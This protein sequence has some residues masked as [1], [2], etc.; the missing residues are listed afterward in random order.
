MRQLGANRP[1]THEFQSCKGLVQVHRPPCHLIFI[2][3]NRAC[4]LAS[5]QDP[6]RGFSGGSAINL[7]RTVWRCGG[8]VVAFQSGRKKDNDDDHAAIQIDPRRTGP[9]SQA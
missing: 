7:T 6:R 5:V 9:A 2:E 8:I 1:L 4:C 3:R